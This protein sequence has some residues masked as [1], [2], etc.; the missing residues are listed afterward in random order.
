MQRW[1]LVFTI[2]GTLAA[3]GGSYSA[4]TYP[5]FLATVLVAASSPRRTFRFTPTSRSLDVALIAIAFAMVM[6]LMPLPRALVSSLS[7]HADD[8]RATLRLD[9]AALAGHWVPLSIEPRATFEALLV[10]LASTLTFWSARAAFAVG[11]VRRFCRA[12]A[13]VALLISLAALIQR[14]TT[15][16]LIYGFWPPYTPGAQPFGP[17]FNRNHFAAWIL[18]VVPLLAGYLTARV[19][20]RTADVRERRT[21]FR[22]FAVAGA[23]LLIVLGVLLLT[24]AAALSRSALIGLA[25]AMV[26]AGI[27]SRN[28]AETRIGIAGPIV[29]V[30]VA[31][32]M[33]LLTAVDVDQWF[34]RINSTLSQTNTSRLTIWRETLPLIRDFWLTGSGAGT[35]SIAMLLY[36][37]SVIPMPHLGTVAHFNQAH[38]HYFQVAAEGGLLL[39]VPVV[40]AGIAFV[41]NAR[42]A[43]NRDLGEAMWIR[44]GAA[45]ALVAIATQSIWETALRMPANALLCAALA[46]IVVHRR[47]SARDARSS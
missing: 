37:Q 14:A 4:T 12:L 16:R 45:T 6:Q 43:I 18:M 25:A 28:R 9:A 11:G 22:I 39:V 41:R 31:G 17:F 8:V 15:P 21:I 13:L 26:G 7:P 29:V 20:T 35:Y 3:F 40:A 24:L 34:Q 42:A 44:I 32:M 27:I 1:L 36:Q 38:S 46:G 10:F 19:R 30:V 47:E 2:A 33:F 5:I 23:P